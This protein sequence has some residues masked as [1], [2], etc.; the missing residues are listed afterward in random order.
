MSCQEGQFNI[1]DVITV[2][3]GI[4]LRA[5]SKCFGMKIENG[6][7]VQPFLNSKVISRRI[8][9]KSN[10]FLLSKVFQRFFKGSSTSNT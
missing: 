4:A 1:V 2:I 3:N 5:F 6:C 7:F 10:Q 9:G 8:G